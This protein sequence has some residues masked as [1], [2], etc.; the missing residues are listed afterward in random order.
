MVKVGYLGPAGT[1]SHQAAQQE[2]SGA[3]LIPQKSIGACFESMHKAEVDYAVVPFENSTNGQVVFTYD[4]LR[5]WFMKCGDSTPT[6]KFKVVGECF[7]SIHHS[8]IGFQPDL[9]KITK[10]YSHPQVWGQ[11]SSFLEGLNVERIDTSSTSRAVELVAQSPLVEQ[12][13]IA[14]IGSSAA[15]KLHSV[16]VVVPSVEDNTSNT[17]RFLV[18]GTKDEISQTSIDVR[19]RI[20][21]LSFVL[22]H[23]NDM[24]SLSHVLDVF[25]RHKVNLVSITTRP[26]KLL[27]WQYVFF[28]EC[29]TGGDA[30]QL[31]PVYSELGEFTEELRI[32]G[33]FP[34]S[35]DYAGK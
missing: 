30:S 28:L 24:G 20:T 23:F 27:K 17:T 1:Y 7:V 13:E 14:A 2:F 29:V 18:L 5:D 19:D 8:L 15:S 10:V 12:N 21:L 35:V 33:W 31:D 6:P 26:A 25:A 9:S 16:P 34:R 32:M 11:C 4:L 3:E 22:K